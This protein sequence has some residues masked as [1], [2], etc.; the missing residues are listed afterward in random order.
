MHKVVGHT[1]ANNH[2]NNTHMLPFE[3]TSVVML[4]GGNAKRS[5]KSTKWLSSCM[6]SRRN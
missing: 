2:I 6:K 1:Q 5:P 4:C 3:A